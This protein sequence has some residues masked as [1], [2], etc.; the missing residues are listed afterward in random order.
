MG[1]ET[2]VRLAAP[3]YNYVFKDIPPIQFVLTFVE[4]L[5]ADR[6]VDALD[7]VLEDYWILRGRLEVDAEG[8]ALVRVPPYRPG[9]IPVRVLEPEEP[10]EPATTEPSFEHIDEAA[11]G[12]GGPLARVRIEQMPG[13]TSIGVS[14]THAV[15][16]GKGLFDLLHAW[17]RAYSGDDWPVPS[18]DRNPLRVEL[19]GH[20]E[21]PDATEVERAT[22]YLNQGFRYPPPGAVRRDRLVFSSAEVAALRSD[23]QAKG[24]TLNDVLTAR[25]WRAFAPY[26][27]RRR[28]D[29]HTLRCPV[30]VRRH[31][32]ELDP[33]YFGT[34]LRDAVMELDTGQFDTAGLDDLAWVVHYG[35]RMIDADVVARLLRCYE[36]LRRTEGPSAFSRLA[37]DGLIV[38]NFSRT[39]VT[40][41]DFG[42]VAPV[43]AL[44]L[45]LSTRTANIVPQPDGVEIQI[46]RRVD[47]L[48]TA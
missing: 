6:L 16:D 40:D 20:E 3:D 41:L 47:P 38:S 24:L 29:L 2:V 17:G 5:D 1:N 15:C 25:A 39:R 45:S 46:L 10:L 33:G 44:N 35:V 12:P 4:N 37:A 9:A 22:T 23:A 21:A 27:P 7:A 42:G 11:R 26:A 18:F 13:S 19:D 36:L 48:P 28:P 8:E 43:H 32:S 14:V 31:F 34:T 30:D